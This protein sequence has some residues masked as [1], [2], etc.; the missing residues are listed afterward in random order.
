MKRT[1]ALTISI[2]AIAVVLSI[3]LWV[4]NENKKP[5]QGTDAIEMSSSKEDSDSQVTSN[6]RGPKPLEPGSEKTAQEA[7]SNTRE[8]PDVSMSEDIMALVDQEVRSQPIPELHVIRGNVHVGMTDKDY[9]NLLDELRTAG[10]LK[11][12][13]QILKKGLAKTQPTAPAVGITVTLQSDSGERKAITDAEGNYKFTAVPSGSYEVLASSDSLDAKMAAKRIVRVNSDYK[14]DLTLQSDLVSIRG[15]VTDAG[16]NAIAGVRVKAERGYYA[17]S[18][19]HMIPNDPLPSYQAFSG[20][21][22]VFELH[23]IEP[24]SIMNAMDYLE[25]ENKQGVAYLTI[26]ADAEGYKAKQEEVLLLTE[27]VLNRARRLFS[28]WITHLPGEYMLKK[29]IRIPDSDGNWIENI[30]IALEKVPSE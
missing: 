21:D 19:T 25:D 12:F 13:E 8:K 3:F 9:E 1:K 29:E 10:S 24:T 16:G 30:D 17:T 18:N 6:M 28:I 7:I 15:R 11:D 5:N 2:C 26:R 23:G 27:K 22:G 4:S 14:A 20:A